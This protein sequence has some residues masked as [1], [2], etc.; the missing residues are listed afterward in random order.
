M[1]DDEES[2]RIARVISLSRL[3]FGFASALALA[4]AVL[5]AAGVAAPAA[6]GFDEPEGR[7][8]PGFEQVQ[9]GGTPANPA[10]AAPKP[11][12]VA[13]R[14]AILRKGSKDTGCM[15]TLE[16]G[17]KGQSGGKALLSP[18]CRDQGVVIFD[19]AFWRIVKG[20]LVLIARKG[21][22][23]H[24]DLQADGTWQKD[25]K[26]GKALILKRM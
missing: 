18:A 16:E 25:P 1:A 10:A 20:R 5:P 23:T 22:A 4:L 3:G 26:E 13:G 8:I 2:R 17:G 24:L 12:A 11:S 19:P 9:S 7:T 14:Y 21:H 15:L 6:N